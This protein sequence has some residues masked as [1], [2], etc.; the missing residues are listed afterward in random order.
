MASTPFY[1]TGDEKEHPTVVGKVGKSAVLRCIITQPLNFSLD[2]LRVYWQTLDNKV[3][4]AFL[5][6]DNGEKYQALEYQ[7]RTQLFWDKLQEGNFSLLLSN[8]SLSDKQ[9]YKC[10]VMKNETKYNVIHEAFITL[11][12]EANYIQS[13]PSDPE[14]N[15]VEF[16]KEVTFTCSSSNGYPEPKIHWTDTTHS[17]LPAPS[18]TFH[19]NM[20]QYSVFSILKLNVTADLNLSCIIENQLLQENL[21]IRQFLLKVR[22]N[23][24]L[25]I[26][27]KQR[28]D[29]T[30]A[31]ISTSCVIV[32]VAFVCV[33]LWLYKRKPSH[34]FY[35]GCIKRSNCKYTLVELSLNIGRVDGTR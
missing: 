24:S 6:G 23:G 17:S 31:T 32:I 20:S 10:I 13:Y 9:I 7:G 15:E 1:G 12:V 28:R 11:N 8:L 22:N 2:Q 29:L 16:G 21:T 30:Q 25:P 18:V 3:V 35:E 4:Y 26:T 33:A 19:R 5:S 34:V 14:V 27:D